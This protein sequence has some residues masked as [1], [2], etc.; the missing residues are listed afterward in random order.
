MIRPFI[1]ITLI[2]AVES[3]GTRGERERW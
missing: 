3:M 1:I 2:Q